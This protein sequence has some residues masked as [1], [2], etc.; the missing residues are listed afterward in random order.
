LWQLLLKG[1]EEVRSAPDPLVA[2]QMALLRVLHAADLPD[3]GML[4]RK[5]EEIA[6]RPAAAP[7]FAAEPGLAAPALAQ[8]PALDWAAL[9]DQV[10]Q[11]AGLGVASTMRM[12]VR[13]VELAP[14]LLRYAQPPAFREDIATLLRTA[15]A[16]TTGE[17]WQVEKASGE[18]APTL[19]EQDEARSRA[20]A[21][22]VR[23]SP[24][25]AATL[26]AFPD[27]ELI[28]DDRQSATG[29]GAR[30]WRR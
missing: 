10:E 27:A 24:L 12:Q 14:G 3:P 20:D 11:T 1:H 25:V 17:A 6:S 5:L 29:G 28:D 8:R 30:N 13:V 22:A 19:V 2:A 26:A 7:A 16:K 15:L 18:G 9:V 4:A 23:A 21:D